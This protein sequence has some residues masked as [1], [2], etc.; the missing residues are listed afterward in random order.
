MIVFTLHNADFL[1]CQCPRN[2]KGY[3]KNNFAQFILHPSTFILPS[4]LAHPSA[5]PVANRAIPLSSF[6]L[7]P[8]TVTCPSLSIGRSQPRSSFVVKKS[9]R[10]AIRESVSKS[11]GHPHLSIHQH[12]QK[13][14]TQ[15][16]ALDRPDKFFNSCF[17]FRHDNLPFPET[18]ISKLIQVTKRHHTLPGF[19][20]LFCIHPRAIRCHKDLYHP[21]HAC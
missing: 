6:C 8:S 20:T 3:D 12:R 17:G 4:S 10:G 21:L 14:T 11:V 5:R 9:V 19:L 2:S 13:P 15:F 16:T 7:H 1:L 18:I